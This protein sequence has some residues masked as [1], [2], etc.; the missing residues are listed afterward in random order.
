M[1]TFFVVEIPLGSNLFF[2]LNHLQN[3]KSSTNCFEFVKK[4]LTNK[5]SGFIQKSSQIMEA[6]EESD[7]KLFRSGATYI[8]WRL[9]NH[10]P[11]IMLKQTFPFFYPGRR[12]PWLVS[13][14]LFHATFCEEKNEIWKVKNTDWKNKKQWT[15]GE[16]PCCTCVS[17]RTRA[18]CTVVQQSSYNVPQMKGGCS[19]DVFI[20]NFVFLCSSLP[21]IF[22]SLVFFLN[23]SKM[24]GKNAAFLLLS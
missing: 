12:L 18:Y 10:P 4:I 8:Y 5:K 17:S 3:S 1:W 9:I 2:I 22:F 13:V 20:K 16:K 21:Y 14:F 7:L 11:K 23:K 19:L 24:A 6:M 15:M